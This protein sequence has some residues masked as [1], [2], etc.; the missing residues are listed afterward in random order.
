MYVYL[1]RVQPEYIRYSMGS[2]YNVIHKINTFVSLAE[3]FSQNELFRI[4]NCLLDFLTSVVQSDI[5]QIHTM[6]TE[7]MV[8]LN[9]NRL[10]SVKK[11]QHFWDELF[12]TLPAV[13][14]L[15]DITEAGTLTLEPQHI[16]SV[17]L[18]IL[19]STDSYRKTHVTNF[20]RSQTENGKLMR[21][22]CQNIYNKVKE[23]M[24]NISSNNL[25]HVSNSTHQYY[26]HVLHELYQLHLSYDCIETLSEEMNVFVDELVKIL[27]DI[28]N[29]LHMSR[30]MDEA[31]YWDIMR[32][33]LDRLNATSV[34]LYEQ[35]VLY[36]ANKTTKIEISNIIGQD[37]LSGVNYLLEHIISVITIKGIE[38]LLL[39]TSQLD[40]N[41]HAWY[42][43][44][45]YVL[46]TSVPRFADRGVKYLHIWRN[47][48]ALLETDEILK[49]KYGVSD[50]WHSWGRDGA[51][52]IFIINGGAERLI[53]NIS[54]E[55]TN[56]L[57]LELMRI[58]IRLQNAQQEAIESLSNV[59]SHHTDIRRESSMG[60]EFML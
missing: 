60:K 58:K 13:L 31:S 9:S 12:A 11:N 56:I 38:P 14:N 43:K 29:N 27:R 52:D 18:D 54:R 21:R 42:E 33:E 34:W 3:K 8:W 19:L 2:L 46:Q 35:T 36:A 55:F 23:F 59:V 1:Q 24:V 53:M 48:V 7:Y 25:H 51:L 10:I 6:F 17:S 32:Q 40:R 39:Q 16:L 30:D 37:T 22:E 26:V 45:L 49:F 5:G 47:P 50:A 20:T 15:T 41:V 44:A 4:S 28:G 57:Y